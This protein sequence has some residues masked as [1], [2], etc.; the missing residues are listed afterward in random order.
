M[1]IYSCYLKMHSEILSGFIF[2]DLSQ[3]PNIST[4]VTI[5]KDYEH[6]DFLSEISL[7]YVRYYYHA[8]LKLYCTAHHST[9]NIT[10][11]YSVSGFPFSLA[12]RALW[13]MQKHKGKIFDTQLTSL[14]LLEDHMSA[15]TADDLKRLK[16]DA[17]NFQEYWQGNGKQYN[18]DYV[19]HIFGVVGTPSLS[20]C[21]IKY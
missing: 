15:M 20:T 10:E 16:V 13:R 14:D 7:A 9:E 8:L 21:N 19:S 4:N 2:N 18:T 1:R 5:C 12:A 6:C 11:K 17:D 3:S